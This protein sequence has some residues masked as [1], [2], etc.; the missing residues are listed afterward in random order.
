LIYPDGA[1]YEGKLI[2]GVPHG[3]GSLFNSNGEFQG[4]WCQ[5]KLLGNKRVAAGELE[6]ESEYEYYDE[7]EEGGEHE[8]I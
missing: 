5:G 8:Q 3:Q 1:H 7:E 6:E 2:N 4:K